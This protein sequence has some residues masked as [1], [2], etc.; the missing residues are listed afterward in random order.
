MKES[1]FTISENK[2]L[3]D[4]VFRLRLDGD[5]GAMERPGQFIDIK[6]EGFFLRRP[7]SVCDYDKSGISVLYETVGGGTEKLSTLPVGTELNVLTGL[8]NGFELSKAGS[9]P[10]LVGGGTGASPMYCT[11]RALVSGGIIPT[12][13][14]GFAR[15]EDILL[16]D[17]FRALGC[18]T[19]ITTED[20]SRGIKG[21]VTDALPEQYSFVYSCGPDA[22]MRALWEKTKSSGE[23]SF[24]ARMGCGFGACMGCTMKTASGFKRVCKDG[25]VFTREEI[26]WED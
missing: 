14:L 22:M 17:E 7:L 16:E 3:T 12:V 20:G 5:T 11:A 25:P 24:A 8:G 1:V 21:Y 2:R 23:Y 6:I 13:I 15:S 10:L 4:R 18:N 19:I 9:R 26:L